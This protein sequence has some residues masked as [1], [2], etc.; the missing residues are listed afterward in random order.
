MSNNQTTSERS[1][2]KS[3]WTVGGIVAVAAIVMIF[4]WLKVVRGAEDP[5]SSFPTFVAKRGP[6]TISVLESGTI[7]PR[8]Q[9]TLRNEVEGS[10]TI[11][12]L[13]PDGSLVKKGDLLVELDAST[14]KDR[15][16]DQDIA[17]QRADASY[18]GAKES[19]A[20]TENQ[21]KSDIEKAELTLKFARQDLQQYLDGLYPRDVNEMTAK[22]RLAE[23]DLKRS[24]D[25]ND[26]SK[27]LY[28]EKYLSET[29]YLADKLSVQRKKLERDVA[30]NNLVILQDFTYQRQI[31]Q[32]TSDVNQA[33][34][35]LERTKR[36]ASADV[37]RA[38][39]DLQAMELEYNRQKDKMK[40]YEDQLAKTTIYA[41]QDGMVV[42]ATS[43]GGGRRGPFDRRE[44]M[45]IGVT[46]REREDMINL[47]TANLMKA[48]VDIH[49]TSL[50]KVRIGLPTVITVDALAGKKFL[51]R[52][53]RIAPLPD[54]RMQWANPDLKIY[55]TDIYL[56]DND[57]SLR[58][59]MSCKAEIIIAQ[60][61]DTVYVPVQAVLRIAGQPTV[62]VVNKDGTHT[63]RKVEI[64][65]DDNNM[66]RI[67]GGL[68]EGEVVLLTPPLKA[69]TIESGSKVSG[70]ESSDGASTFQERVNQRLEEANG[71]GSAERPSQR[72]QNQSMG[73]EGDR[74]GQQEGLDGP[75]SDQM[76]QMR[77]RFENM[78]DEERQKAME[79][80]K[81]RFENMSQEE[82]DAMRQRFQGGGGTRQG[83]GQRQGS[84]QRQGGT[85]QDQGTNQGSRGAERDQ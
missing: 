50:E 56:E 7:S 28:E 60:Y 67:I 61:E 33:E 68:E 46:V 6:L 11:V 66:V 72:E 27:R 71:N 40:K 8:E 81:Q 34:M 37:I 51:G 12:S 84:G 76:D 18:V 53:E 9:I 13:V 35:A 41:P 25:V 85:G 21:A 79:Q 75:A 10:T 64:G 74:Q 55:P 52:V 58:T 82:R 26:W 47:P 45:E 59:G 32:L 17:V 30:S 24:E 14:L 36:K 20:V 23:E 54:A 80:M 3:F 43:S 19:L 48:T 69:A 22:I 1:G 62:Y 15:I 73:S 77:R 5:M 70:I 42:Y 29:E 44:P 78:S 39:A 16:I 57:S 63:E 31:E 38:K 83:R 2:L 65:L 4:I 49:E